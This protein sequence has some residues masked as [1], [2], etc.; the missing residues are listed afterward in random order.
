MADEGVAQD[1]SNGLERSNDVHAF[2]FHKSPLLQCRLNIPVA[3]FL[4]KETQLHTQYI[5]IHKSIQGF[6]SLIH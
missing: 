4:K 1:G 3:V 6:S 5:F 2:F